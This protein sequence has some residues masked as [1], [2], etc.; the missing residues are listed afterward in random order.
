MKKKN[1]ACLVVL[2]EVLKV[3]ILKL[4]NCFAEKLAFVLLIFILLEVCIL[5]VLVVK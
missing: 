3:G 1:I 5:Y 4:I 2:V